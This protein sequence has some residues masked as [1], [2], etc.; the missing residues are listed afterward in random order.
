MRMRQALLAVP[1]LLAAVVAAA[2]APAGTATA[3]ESAAPA[4]VIVELRVWQH[5]R[6]TDS[7]WVS[8]RPSG[9]DWRTL[10]T[11]PFP[12]DN[13]PVSYYPYR[14]LAIAGVGLRVWQR[15]GSPERVYVRACGNACPHHLLQAFWHRLG[16]IELPLDD[17]HSPS[18]RY[19]Y[20]DLRVAVPF[21]NPELLADREHLLGLRD[22]LAGTGTLNWSA[23]TAIAQWDGVSLGGTPPRVTKLELAGRGLR[24]EMS[25]W[26]G[27]L[28]GL[29][30]LRLENNAIRGAIAPK[31][32]QL[33][34]LTHAYLRGNRLAGCLPPSLRQIANND[35]P[36]SRL[37][38]CL[39][40]I[41][42]SSHGEHV[43]TAGSYLF[44]MAEGQP[45]LIFDVPAGIQLKVDGVVISEPLPDFPPAGP[46]LLLSEAYGPSRLWLDVVRGVESGRRLA[47]HASW[48]AAMFDRIIESAWLGEP[49]TPSS[50]PPTLIGFVGGGAGEIVLEW[51]I[52][53]AGV[54]RWQY[55][56][57]GPGDTAWGAWTDVPDSDAST[58]SH[59]L[60]GLQP[61]QAYVFQ[62]RPL[63]AQGPGDAYD[64][65]QVVPLEVGPDG[66]P[67]GIGQVVEYGRRFRV[68]RTSYTFTA[69][70]GL[71]IAVV[72]VVRSLDGT[73]RIRWEEPKS[74]SYMIYES[75]F[76]RDVARVIN[77]GAP[78][79]AWELFDQL[80]E[81]IREE[82]LP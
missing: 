12:L 58:T 72:E 44:R 42:I 70:H 57:W 10:G 29:T 46:D 8:A 38:D 27:N 66:I 53:R 56:E 48:T 50:R 78:P 65:V 73:T 33:T 54:A 19:R 74:G 39:P 47:P 20:G 31:L 25:G 3:D 14:D 28:T 51:T 43:L 13:G 40:P 77:E 79:N 34:Q 5:V 16:A 63:T 59:R 41:D 67:Y 6:N 68:L 52:A 45:P 62:V 69:P 49:D 61:D 2:A 26:L 22:T 82:P 18:G 7:I 60:T 32:S 71:P 76:G 17:G 55:R 15:S 75:H 23:S 37:P 9:G 30:E 81:S 1:I 64:S 35:I 24:G 21:S 11:I 4:E 80:L 36:S